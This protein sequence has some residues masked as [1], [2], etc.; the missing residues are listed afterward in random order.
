MHQHETYRSAQHFNQSFRPVTFPACKGNF[1]CRPLD[2]LISRASGLLQPIEIWLY[3]ACKCS[4]IIWRLEEQNRARMGLVLLGAS[5]LAVY[6]GCRLS[7]TVNYF[8]KFFFFCFCSLLAATIFIPL[9]FFKP[10]DWRNGLWVYTEFSLFVCLLKQH[11]WI[12]WI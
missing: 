3:S 1:K 4:L 5:A 7:P 6:V 9:M 10:R 11:W 8:T 12:I 2:R